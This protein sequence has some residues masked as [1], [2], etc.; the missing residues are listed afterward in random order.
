MDRRIHAAIDG[1]SLLARD[2]ALYASN[3]L[4]FASPAGQA[5]NEQGLCV[6][7]H[8]PTDTLAG[9]DGLDL[10]HGRVG[11]DGRS[12]TYIETCEPPLD[13]DCPV[14]LK[15][16]LDAVKKGDRVRLLLAT[17]AHYLRNGWY[18]DGLRPVGPKPDDH[19]EGELVG[20]P[21]W[22]FRLAAATVGRWLSDAG[23]AMNGSNGPQNN[24][25]A[26]GIGEPAA[27][28]RPLRRLVPAGS[29]YWLD[30]LEVGSTSLADRWLQST[31][32]A[33]AARDGYGL[34]LFGLA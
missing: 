21:G 33:E 30:V 32:R 24:G 25:E 29:V 34:G 9:F 31:C 3:A 20:L 8:A 26:P 18:P 6:W 22:R 17:P 27:H 12:A 7:V 28:A 1:N 19:L 16:R 10:R 23:W 13:S 5:R 14:A 2:R 11:A 4:E 15:Q